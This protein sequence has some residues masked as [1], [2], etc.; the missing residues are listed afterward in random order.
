MPYSIPFRRRLHDR[1]READVELARAH[2]QRERDDEV[3]EL[4][5][6]DQQAEPDD[7]DEDRHAGCSPFA[8]SAACLRV[9][10]DEVVEVARGRAVDARERLLD[11]RRD[12]EEP[13][14]PVEERRTATS[15]AAL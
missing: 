15:F 8:A 1:G 13:D 9:G 14:P 6:E 7:R 11:D 4:V 3:P 10:G 5:D 12:V 2:P